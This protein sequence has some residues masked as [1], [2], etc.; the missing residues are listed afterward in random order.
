MTKL[1]VLYVFHI[2]NDRVNHFIKNCIFNDENVDFILIS[3]NKN[4]D[5]LTMNSILQFSNFYIKR[6]MK[7][8]Q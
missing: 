6:A 8:L 2:Y 4:S 7:I 1:L 5:Q 3:N